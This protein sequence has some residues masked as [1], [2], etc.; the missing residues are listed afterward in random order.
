MK[1]RTWLAAG[2]RIVAILASVLFVSSPGTAAELWIGGSSISIT[3]DQP[4]ALS[5]QMRTRISTGVESPCLAVA[6]A[7]ESRKGDQV[8]DQAVMV[9]CDLVAIRTGILAAVRE[10]IQMKL[11]D[12]DPNKIFLSATHTHT[13]PEML[14]GRYDIEGR[15]VMSPTAY[16]EFLIGQVTTAIEQAWQGRKPGAV[17]WGLGHAIVP[18]NRR[19]VYA[20]G[21]AQMYGAT[22]RDDFRGIEGPEDHGVEVLFFWDGQRKLMATIVN[23]A[24]PSQEVEGLSVVN[25]DFWHNVRE[26]LKAAHGPDL[27]VL[28]WTGAA[29][30]QSPRPMFRKEAEERMRRLR[31]LTRLE[32]I[33]RRIV[34]AWD[35]AYAGAVQEIHADVPLIHQ[36][37]QVSLPPR[38]IT[39]EEY[40]QAQEK[41]AALQGQPDIQW[42]QRWHQSVVD[43]YLRQREGIFEPYLMEL[44]VLRLGDVAIATNEFEYYT[45]FGLQIK[46]R[47]NALQTFVVQLC[48][49]GSYV[50][51]ARAVRGGGYSA[52]PESNI[53]GPEGGQELVERTVER[54]NSLW[55][56]N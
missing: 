19:I 36:V 44:H 32:E 47:S 43:R 24:C 7:L 11:P 45:E 33:T 53:V 10:R 29:G 37:Q 20:N 6:L 39:T 23:V 49:P 56:K 17:G 26:K 38:E 5:G 15:N 27:L 4:V 9:A 22:R 28:G 8:L 14:E 12:L 2:F 34:H 46:A 41:I 3:P 21:T 52:I 50:P 13:A 16:T 48:G 40:A 1:P 42:R 31:G 25:A 55:E 35:E 18:Y 51:T 30:D 54:I